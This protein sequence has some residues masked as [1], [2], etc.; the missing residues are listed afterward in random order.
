MVLPR[1]DIR[2]YIVDP[3]DWLIAL[4]RLTLILT[5]VSQLNMREFI[6][7]DG[8]GNRSL[9]TFDWRHFGISMN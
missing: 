4:A 7:S 8:I 5:S 2:D 6:E 3:Y 1:C 9:V